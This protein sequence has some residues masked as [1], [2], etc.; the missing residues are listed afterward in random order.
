MRRLVWVL[1][2]VLPMMLL[3]LDAVAAPAKSAGAGAGNAAPKVS[4][5]QPVAPQEDISGPWTFA[6][7]LQRAL[8]ANPDLLAAKFQAEREEGVRL[9]MRSRLLP[10][11][12]ASGST[13]EREDSLI[14]RTPGELQVEPS[15]RTAISTYGWDARV[16][17]RQVVFD[18]FGSWSDAK[19][20]KL[21]TKRAYLNFLDVANRTTV[22][23]RQGFDA[24]LMRR[25]ILVS[26][27]RRIDN[28]AKLVEW[29]ARKEAVGEVAQLDSLRA[30][31]ELL[32]AK[33]ELADAE[34][35][36]IAAEQAFRRLLQL[37]NDNQRL[38]LAGDLQM[39]QFA[40]DF[41]QALGQAMQHRPDLEAAELAVRASKLQQRSQ[42]ADYLPKFEAFASYDWRSSYYNSGNL[43]DGWT[44]GVSGRWNLFDGFESRGRR[45]S[46]AADRRVAETR[47]AEIEQAIGSRL[48]ELYQTLEQSRVSIT[49][50]EASVGFA[51]QALDQANKLYQAGQVG[52]EQVL[53]ADVVARRAEHRRQETIYS[54][55][56]AVSQIEYAMGG[57]PED[58]APVGSQWKR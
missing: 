40:T 2:T 13:D 39:R 57:Q 56:V 51:T 18:S 15:K 23:V 5:T 54:Y 17:I 41:D 1:G 32:T 44:A 30:Q 36:L 14:D 24:I 52:L 43:L 7:A 34:Q 49:A 21:M 4:A 58:A 9:Q 46:A 6:R 27:H 25:N 10:R 31:S 28:L 26:E 48:R 20:Q 38:E 8:D 45:V 12:T 53:Q 16:E 42:L 11:L 33:S 22:L 47:L 19:R 55:N 35:G 29:T 37:P 3:G 50:Q